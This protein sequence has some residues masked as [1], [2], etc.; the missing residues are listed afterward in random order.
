M[1]TSLVLAACGG[2]DDAGESKDTGSSDSGTTTETASGGDAE[3][4]FSQKCSSC[5]AADLT[6]GVGPDL[7]KVG[8]KL[9]KDEIEKIIV[10]GQNAM[11][12]GQLTGAD[13]TTV[14]DWLAAKK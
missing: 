2:G 4:L 13:A 8:A 5:H 11:P 3:K 14:A 6:G 9:S 7:T 12:A 10:D 1:G